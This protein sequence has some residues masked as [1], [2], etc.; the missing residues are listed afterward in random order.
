MTE[1]WPEDYGDM[2]EAVI[3][4]LARED[5]ARALV[6]EIEDVM[7]SRMTDSEVNSFLVGDLGSGYLPEADGYTAPVWL[8]AVRALALERGA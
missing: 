2:R 7:S 6:K 3:D 1:D 5:L 8:L 4:F